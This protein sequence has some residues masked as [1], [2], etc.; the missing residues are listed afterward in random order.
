MEKKASMNKKEIKTAFT[1][2]EILITISILGIIVAITIPAALKS[3]TEALNRTKVKKAMSTYEKIINNIV[4]EKGLETQRAFNSWAKNDASE[5]DYSEQLSYFKIAEKSAIDGLRNC[6]FKTS[7][8]IWWDIC[9]QCNNI[10]NPII[11]L[12]EKLKNESRDD[13]EV[14]AR[15]EKDS[16]GKKLYVYALLS[17]RDNSGVLRVNDNGYINSDGTYN[18]KLYMNKLYNFLAKKLPRVS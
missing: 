16:N 3:Q 10:A 13:L 2:A 9:A 17:K 6:R 5:N 11:I 18:Q 4:A 12:D 7:D 15:R 8:G 1:L 14:Y